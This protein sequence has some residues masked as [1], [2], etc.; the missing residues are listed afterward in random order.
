MIL[1]TPLRVLNRPKPARPSPAAPSGTENSV[2]P[3]SSQPCPARPPPSGSGRWRSLAA[4]TSAGPDNR[5][6]VRTA[7][8]DRPRAPLLCAAPYTCRWVV[9]EEGPTLFCVVF[10]YFYFFFYYRATW[11]RW[12]ALAPSMQ[13]CWVLNFCNHPPPTDP[14]PPPAPKHTRHTRLKTLTPL[15]ERKWKRHNKKYHVCVFLLI[16]FHLIPTISNVKLIMV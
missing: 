1:G 3:G 16:I 12:Q 8:A 4:E 7:G 11:S 9:L 15:Y 14:A 5:R 10:F 2:T 6:S 13:I